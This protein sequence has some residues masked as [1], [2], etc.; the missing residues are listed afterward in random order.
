[1]FSQNSVDRLAQVEEINEK[2]EVE[3]GM[4]LDVKGKPN[5]K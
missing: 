1:M 3:S 2:Y 5:H 4:S